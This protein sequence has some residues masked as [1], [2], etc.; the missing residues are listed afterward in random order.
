MAPLLEKTLDLS[1]QYAD[2][3]PGYDHIADPLIAV[4]DYGMSVATIQP[5]FEELRTQLV[6]MVQAIS[7]QE[8]ADDSCLRRGFTEVQQ[9]DYSLNLIRQ[10]GYDTAAV[11]RIRRTIRS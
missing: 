11:A 6:P 10:L 8:A 3:F 7:A 2:Y 9:L 4:S 5:I 1:R